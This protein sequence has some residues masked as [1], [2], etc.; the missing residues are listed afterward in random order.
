MTEQ[1]TTVRN[2]RYDDVVHATDDGREPVCD[3]AM[4]PACAPE[5]TTDPVTCMWCESLIS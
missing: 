3:D 4:I 5:L 1:S 2:L